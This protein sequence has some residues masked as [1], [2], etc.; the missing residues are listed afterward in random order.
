VG[1]AIAWLLAAVGLAVAELFVGTFVLLMFAIGALAAAGAAALGANLA[2]DAGV[3][4]IVCL[5]SLVAIRPLLRRT[6][7]G[8]AP[9][10]N[11]IGLEAI[12]GATG[13]VLEEVDAD[14]GL[15]KIEGE[16]WSARP[17]DTTQVIAA[18]ER[19]RVIEIKGAT[20]LVW[21]D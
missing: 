4:V 16:V 11:R 1:V 21:R 9:D 13:L 7:Q 10:G 12:E 6:L 5:L 19:V 2:V 8:S 15:V 3:F 17:Y 14:R 18:G 20:A